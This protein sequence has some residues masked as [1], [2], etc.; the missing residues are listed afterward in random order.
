MASTPAL[1]ASGKGKWAEIKLRG[2]SASY[3]KSRCNT[4]QSNRGYVTTLKM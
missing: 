2:K 4:G 3:L 1:L